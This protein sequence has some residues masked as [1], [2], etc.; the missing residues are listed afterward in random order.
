MDTFQESIDKLVNANCTVTERLRLDCEIVRQQ[1]SITS[2]YKYLNSLCILERRVVNEVA[3]H[4]GANAPVTCNVFLNNVY[5]T[6]SRGDGLI[7]ATPTGST[8]YS[9]SCGG[10]MIHPS[11]QCMLLTPISVN[12]PLSFRPTVLS[13]HFSHVKLEIP[14]ESRHAGAVCFDSV[15]KHNVELQHLDHVMIVKSDFPVY[16]VNKEDSH[17]DWIRS[18]NRKIYKRKVE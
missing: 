15:Y 7:V 9:L 12:F 1:Q 2:M 17:V 4:R 16:T 6:T 14:I 5:C 10:S 11:L 8:G 18:V 3:I 13:A